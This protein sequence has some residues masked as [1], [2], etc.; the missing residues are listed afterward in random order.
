M[1][2]PVSWVLTE[3]RSVLRLKKSQRVHKVHPKY[4]NKSLKL[5]LK[6]DESWSFVQAKKHPRWLWWV[7]E[8]KSGDVVAFVFGRRTH[9]TFRRLLSLLESAQIVV[10]KWITDA[11]CG[12]ARAGLLRLSGSRVAHRKQGS[13]AELGAQA[14]H[15]TNTHQ[16]AGSKDNLLLQISGDSRHTDR[17]VH[18][19]VF[20]RY[21]TLLSHHQNPNNPPIIGT[22]MSVIIS[23]LNK[24]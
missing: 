22:K 15:V 19:S 13:F 18:Q 10:S 8:A 24:T 21:S 4:A 2:P 20:F 6:V 16:T 5:V 14:P 17:V 7:E 12:A 3:I 1:T 9:A 11:W 23:V